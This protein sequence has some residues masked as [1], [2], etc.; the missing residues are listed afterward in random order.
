MRFFLRILVVLALVVLGVVVSRGPVGNCVSGWA[1]L[2]FSRDGRDMALHGFSNG[3]QVLSSPIGVEWKAGASLDD[4]AD[5][6]Y[7]EPEVYAIIPDAEKLSESFEA[8]DGDEKP[9]SVSDYLRSRVERDVKVVP[10]EMITFS[11]YISSFEPF[12]NRPKGY[13]ID[14]DRLMGI[15]VFSTVGG[16]LSGIGVW[17]MLIVGL[18]YGWKHSSA[19]NAEVG[20][21]IDDDLEVDEE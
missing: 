12:G 20:D 9:F 11:S 6:R 1:A 3:F 4:I 8:E 5:R 10:I 13:R 17:A 16:V 15:E 19:R 21:E 7:P 14:R 2:T 18:V